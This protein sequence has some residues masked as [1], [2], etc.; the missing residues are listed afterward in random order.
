MEIGVHTTGDLGL[1][2]HLGMHTEFRLPVEFHQAGL[3]LVVDHAEGV[4]TETLHHAVGTRNAAVRHVPQ[5]VVGGLGVQ[6]DKIPE[7][8]MRAL[9]LWDV[10]VRVRFGGVD[11]IGELDAV[12]DEEHGDVVT[13]QVP[14]AL[15][16]V[17]FHGETTGVTHGVGGTAV[18]QHR[19]E[20]GEHRGFLPLGEHT[21]ATDGGGRTIGLEHT[22]GRGTTGVDHT[23]R[24]ALM[25]E[26]GDLLAEVVVLHEQGAALTGFQR[27]VGVAQAS[28]LGGGEVF[29]LLGVD[30][31]A[32]VHRA[33]GG[34]IGLRGGLIRFAW[35]RRDRDGRLVDLRGSG[36]GDSWVR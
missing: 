21:R 15:L 14:G 2:P 18:A 33:A 8:V 24:D 3:A 9:G 16:G 25:V 26:V 29:T 17:E 27:M 4:D 22:V 34:G 12:L 5:G 11:D 7:G 28:T 10:A 19:G 30:I 35:Q 6:G 13:H 36:G 31:G 1:L 32:D 23:L 20:P